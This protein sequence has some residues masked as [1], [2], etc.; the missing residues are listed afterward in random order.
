MG[1][2]AGMGMGADAAYGHG[3]NAGANAGADACH[4]HGA[5]AAMELMLAPLA[6]ILLDKQ[7][8]WKVCWGP[9]MSY[10]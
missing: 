1:A 10:T 6:P 8:C 9:H 4:G 2:D 5:H 7:F 3:A